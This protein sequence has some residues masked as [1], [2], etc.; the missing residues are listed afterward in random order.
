MIM[1]GIV[2]RRPVRRALASLAALSAVLAGVAAHAAAAQ[3]WYF[4]DS[5]TYPGIRL[6]EVGEDGARVTSDW[7]GTMP[8]QNLRRNAQGFEFDLGNLNDNARPTRHWVAAVQGDQ[9]TLTGDIW[10][11]HVVQAA[12]PATAQEQKRYRF[13]PPACRPWPIWRR[14]GR[15]P[16]RPWGG[17]AGTVLPRVSMTG[18]C[19]KS[20]MP[21]CL[22]A[23]AMR[24]MSM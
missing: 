6:L 24:A 1:L 8:A 16:L 15:R 10:T 17:A 4:A 2:M 13:T 14:M 12:R 5:P 21:W 18:R 9:L 11:S 19:V 22:R 20:P 7:Y 3:V 23:C